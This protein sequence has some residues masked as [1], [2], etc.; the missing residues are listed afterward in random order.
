MPWRPINGTRGVARLLTVGDKPSVLPTGLVENL[1]S[2]IDDGGA[3]EWMSAFKIGQAV[4]IG[5]GPFVNLV[6]KLEYL[7]AAGRV[8]VLLELLGRQVSVTLRSE[9][10]LDAA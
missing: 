3:I 8:R 2:L 4:R 6:G 10:L 1:K 7:D 5:E 9:A